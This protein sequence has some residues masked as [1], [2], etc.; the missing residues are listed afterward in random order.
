MTDLLNDNFPYA[1]NILAGRTALVCGASKGIGRASAM[2]LARA[3]ARV[4]A[5]A[6]S[7]EVLDELIGELHGSGHETLVLDLE[8][9]EAV[10]EVVLGLGVVDIVIN[11]AGGPPG[12]PLLGNNLDEFE[13][14]FARHLHAAHTIAQILAPRMAATG[15]GRFVNI[16]ST[17]VREPIDNIGLSNTLRGAMASWSKSLS[18]ELDP[19]VTINNI[20]PGFTDTARLGSLAGSISER[21]GKTVEEVRETWMNSVPIQRLVDPVETAAAVTFLC[22]PSSGAI[23]GVS[24]A[25]DG[26]RMRS[27]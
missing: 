15:Y 27:I 20:M 25:V 16:I 18:R 17:S 8:D 3:G 12:G 4:I 13:G 2:M 11:N 5:C 19:C 21:T 10:R 14:P 9:V 7:A 24:L 1:E 22:L 6:R 23:R 26:G